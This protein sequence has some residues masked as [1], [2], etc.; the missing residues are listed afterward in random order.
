MGLFE[1]QMFSVSFLCLEKAKKE[2]LKISL[3]CRSTEGHEGRPAC[4]AGSD[5]GWQ[6]LPPVRQFVF[7]I[8]ARVIVLVAF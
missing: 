6:T 1:K 4:L 8:F 5:G 7:T 2:H 3:A